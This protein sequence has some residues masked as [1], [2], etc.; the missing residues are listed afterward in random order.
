MQVLIAEDDPVSRRVLGIALV[1]WGY[2]VVATR[3]GAEAWEALQREDAPRL[4]ILDWMM[5]GLDGVEVCRRVRESSDLGLFHVILLTARDQRED[6]V[7]GLEA[8][9]DDYVVKPFDHAELRA[10]V[11]V[12]E[13]VLGL[14]ERLAE[15]AKENARMDTL[16][17]AACALAHHVRNAVT[18]LLG[19][20]QMFDPE[21]SQDGARLKEIALKEGRRIS[22][23]I[24]A[25]IEVS[26][27]GGV[28]TVAYAG[29]ASRQMLDLEP[30]IQRHLEKKGG[31]L[32]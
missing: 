15:Q 3:D 1:R 26:E 24:D 7:A 29:Q 10:R 19:M 25:L 11:R 20:A 27:T 31:A 8:G 13:R 30:L 9:A 32:P 6:L 14:Q 5:P 17:Q 28:P 23:V 2:E 16:N 18:P 12:G 22:A 21:G 4:A